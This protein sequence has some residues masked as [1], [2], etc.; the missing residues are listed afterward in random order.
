VKISCDDITAFVKTDQIPCNKIEKQNRK[1]K[2]I[3]KKK[4]QKSVPVQRYKQIRLIFFN[5]MDNYNNNKK[6]PNN[7]E[8]YKSLISVADDTS[9]VIFPT[10]EELRVSKQELLS[11]SLSSPSRQQQQVF[12]RLS[13]GAVAFPID[14]STALSRIDR[15]LVSKIEQQEKQEN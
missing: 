14:H 7:T 9:L 8:T 15:L 4:Q 6:K 1:Y 3:T 12:V 2:K 10:I 13:K 5:T 11:S